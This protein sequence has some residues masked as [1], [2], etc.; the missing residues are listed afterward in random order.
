MSSIADSWMDGDIRVD[1]YSC[2][3]SSV[4]PV[5]TLVLPINVVATIS[6]FLD[7]L[8]LQSL[9]TRIIVVFCYFNQ[10]TCILM[11]VGSYTKVF[12]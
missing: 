8:I 10:K 6:P 7:P 12:L 2:W 3:S 1:Y 4:W 11:V 9:Q 5:T